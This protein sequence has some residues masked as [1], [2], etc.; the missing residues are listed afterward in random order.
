MSLDRRTFL[1]LTGV[2][3]GA[4]AT[5]AGGSLAPWAAGE[6]PAV[7]RDR[8]EVVVVGAGSFGAWTAYYLTEM[9][10]DVTVVDQHGPGNNR[11][12]S[13]GE[14]RGVRSSYGDHD[15]WVRWAADAIDRWNEF[16]ERWSEEHGLDLFFDTGD[17]ILREEVDDW[18][19][20]SMASWDEIG[21]DYERLSLEEVRYRWPQVDLGDFRVAVHEP[22]AGVVRAR[23][24]C[25]T[26]MD[27]CERNGG[28]L[29]I[30]R[31][32][33]GRSFDG[34]LVELDLTPGDAL[35]AD[36]YVFCLGPWFPKVFP[37]LMAERMTVPIGH[38][39]YYA[40]PPGDN[41]FVHPNMPSYNVPGITGWPALPPDHRGFRV[42][43]GGR[44]S[45]DPDE[46][47]R[48][49]EGKHLER[50]REFVGERFPALADAPLLQTM[51]CHYEMSSDRNWFIDTHPEMDNVWLAGGGSAEGFKFGPVLGEYIARRVLGEEPAS[52][53][54]RE[55]C[56]LPQQTLGKPAY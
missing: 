2:Q 22:D 33:P 44:P 16:Q 28:R 36:T 20:N 21:H 50:P 35:E 34:R 39:F 17:L 52:A 7:G 49:I 45:Q 53:E 15:L 55:E 19:G 54:V 25:E 18:L 29:R 27:M 23:R 32:E 56:R 37:E 48:Y 9:G 12:T 4:L 51:S 24:T 40:V 11:A 47:V 42:R 6:A 26:V 43:T 10:V 8:P 3:A 30:A 31:A 14:T 46:S 13:M 38:V 41:R 5:G 1:K